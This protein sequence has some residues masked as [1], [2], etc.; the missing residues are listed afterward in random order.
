[1]SRTS[2]ISASVIAAGVLFA[3]FFRGA[4]DL[5]Y[6]YAVAATYLVMVITRALLMKYLR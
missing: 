1:M 6:W 2:K 3:F 4:L 5:G